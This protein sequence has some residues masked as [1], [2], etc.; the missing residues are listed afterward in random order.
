MSTRSQITQ[1][2][3]PL[4]QAITFPALANGGATTWVTGPTDPINT[5]LPRKLRLFSDVPKDQQPAC[6]MTMHREIDEYRNLGAF[7]TRLEYLIY[8]YID[9]SENSAAEDLDNILEG[10]LKIFLAPDNFSSGQFTINGMVYWARVEGRILK[11]PGDIDKQALLLVPI[12]V[13]MP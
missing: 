4:I 10:I 13:E 1:A 12:I 5:T 9:A 8:V 7:R 3:L 6:F 11:D 2:L